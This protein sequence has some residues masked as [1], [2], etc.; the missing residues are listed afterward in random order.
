MGFI[1]FFL[2]DP[3]K[4]NTYPLVKYFNIF[5]DQDGI[6]RMDGRIANSNRY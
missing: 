3:S 6:L 1:I 2:K 4:G 5:M